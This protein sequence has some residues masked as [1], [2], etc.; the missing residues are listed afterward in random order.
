M[1]HYSVVSCDYTT[2]ENLGLYSK[3]G[4]V[5]RYTPQKCFFFTFQH[6][7]KKN[8]ITYLTFLKSKDKKFPNVFAYHCLKST[9]VHYMESYPRRLYD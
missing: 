8:V 2:E 7:I 6:I 1:L 3:S 4:T 5:F 9:V